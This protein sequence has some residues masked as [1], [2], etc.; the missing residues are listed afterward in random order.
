MQLSPPRSGTPSRG[1]ELEV[2]RPD[3]SLLV[4]EFTTR[5]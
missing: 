4:G 2:D 1:V 3:C 5:Q